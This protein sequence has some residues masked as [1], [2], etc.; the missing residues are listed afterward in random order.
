MEGHKAQLKRTRAAYQSK[1]CDDHAIFEYGWVLTRG[2]GKDFESKKEVVLEG[3]R[4][5]KALEQ[6]NPTFQG[7]ILLTIANAYFRLGDL[8]KSRV[9]AQR[10]IQL[11]PKE[12][13]ERNSNLR[14]AI[15]LHKSIRSKAT[16]EGWHVM[17]SIFVAGI[18][19]VATA[20]FA[21]IRYKRLQ[22]STW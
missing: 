3:I 14:K 1:N 15:D 7:F 18:L 4:I 6:E 11:Y 5:L 8:N 12:D 22:R 20:A 19:G 16:E 2:E 17:N 9:H 13:P 21:M 10:L